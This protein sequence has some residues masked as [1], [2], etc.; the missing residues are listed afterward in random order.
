VLGA[1]KQ[2]LYSPETLPGIQGILSANKKSR[3]GE[4]LF[5]VFHHAG[6]LVIGPP[7]KAGLPYI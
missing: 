4:T 3:R 7:G 2:L 1:A 6:S 5:Q